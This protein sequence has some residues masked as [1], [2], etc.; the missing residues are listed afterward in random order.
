MRIVDV[1]RGDGRRKALPS[2]SLA[3]VFS[4]LLVLAGGVLM[5][6]R[7]EWSEIVAILLNQNWKWLFAAVV[8]YW[9]QFPINSYRLALVCRW[10]RGAGFPGVPPFKFI[11]RVTL[12]ASFIA[13]AAPVGIIADAAKI[14]A[15]RF[16]GGI[17]TM[18]AARAT[19]FDRAVAAQWM[20]V[21]GLMALPV[22]AEQNVEILFIGIQ[23]LFCGSVVAGIALLILLPRVLRMFKHPQIAKFA[24]LF[25]SY[26]AMLQVR[27][28]S[29]QALITVT[30]LTL[31]W[32]AIYCLGLASGLMMNLWLVAVFLPF[33]QLINSV[34]FLYMGWGGREFAVAAALGS[35]GG[36]SLNEALAISALWG[37]TMILSGAINGVFL[38]AEWR[39]FAPRADPL[40]VKVDEVS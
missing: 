24:L 33:L 9:V 31:V 40:E 38:L 27:R 29:V 34:P 14:G 5:Y 21:F 11:L 4:M 36:L 10:L 19:L 37:M 22:E 3:I 20:A 7:I 8:I 13:V 39:V 16:F 18:N 28:S 25:S 15:L 12:S 26:P 6:R 32:T 1:R 23:G 30:N 17:S 2:R 35:A